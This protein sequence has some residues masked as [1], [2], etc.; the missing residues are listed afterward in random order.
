MSAGLGHIL[1]PG[2][3][4]GVCPSL[5]GRLRI[6]GAW[7]GVGAA[8]GKKAR[9]VPPSAWLAAGTAAV[10]W[11][12]PTLDGGRDPQDTVGGCGGCWGPEWGW[13]QWESCLLL[14]GLVPSSGVTQHGGECVLGTAGQGPGCPHTGVGCQGDVFLSPP[15][16]CISCGSLN[17]TLEHPLFIGGMCQNCKVW[18]GAGRGGTAWGVSQGARPCPRV[19]NVPGAAVTPWLSPELLFGVRVPVRRRRVPVLLHH[20][21][22]RPRGPHVWQ[23]QLLQV[24]GRGASGGRGAAVQPGSFHWC[25]SS[26]WHEAGSV[27]V[28][29]HSWHVVLLMAVLVWDWGVLVTSQSQ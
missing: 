10:M 8:Q 14:P 25:P 7:R 3:G 15:D 13:G 24:R 6:E 18:C 1:H 9:L 26:V 16:I 12:W 2:C 27:L 22:R 21:L 28:V 17:V 4:V 23:Q 5:P 11:Q 19:P 29:S 20:L